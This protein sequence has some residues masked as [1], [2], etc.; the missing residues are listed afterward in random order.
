MILS[1]FIV[2]PYHNVN[3][4]VSII[5]TCTLAVSKTC[6]VYE[7]ITLL[8]CRAA[9]WPFSRQLIMGCVSA[10]SAVER[11]MGINWRHGSEL[12]Y[13]SRFTCWFHAE[14]GVVFI[15]ERKISQALHVFV[16]CAG[17][18]AGRRA[19]VRARLT[20]QSPVMAISPNCHDSIAL[21]TEVE[22]HRLYISQLSHCWIC[23]VSLCF[24]HRAESIS[25]QKVEVFS[26]PLYWS[27]QFRLP[28]RGFSL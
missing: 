8:H 13:E 27:L 16:V 2:F 23:D 24:C 18:Q 1:S 11:G 12:L 14:L 6:T 26:A 15:S 22:H 17:R 3:F 10:C 7:Q 28:W 9:F 20:H 21:V 25:C 4:K 5:G 19:L